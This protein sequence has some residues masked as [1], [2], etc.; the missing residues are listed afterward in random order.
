MDLSI[1]FGNS[2]STQWLKRKEPHK[3]IPQLGL[4]NNPAADYSN[5]STAKLGISKAI[6]HHLKYSTI[7]SRNAFRLYQ[8]IWLPKM[9]FSLAV[10]LF[11]RAT[12]VKIMK[13]FVHA[14]LPKLGF[15][16]NTTR[17]IIYGSTRYGGFQFKH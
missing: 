12:C 3:S 10:T 6:T 13:P 4:K 5:A 16:R 11:S 7:L 9:Q 1:K 8:N 15:N 17:A 2:T 14:I